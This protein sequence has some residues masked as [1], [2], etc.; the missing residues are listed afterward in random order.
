[1]LLSHLSL[2]AAYGCSLILGSRTI[3]LRVTR[4]RIVTL[5]QI[6]FVRCGI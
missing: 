3:V 5:L 1:M 6:Q 4:S 2:L